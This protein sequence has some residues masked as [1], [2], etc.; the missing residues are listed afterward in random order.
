MQSS[1]LRNK[2]S[3][4]NVKSGGMEPL[5]PHSFELHETINSISSFLIKAANSAI[6]HLQIS[7]ALRTSPETAETLRA[8]NW[9]AA[10]SRT[11]S[12]DA[13]GQDIEVYSWNYTAPPLKFRSQTWL[14][15]HLILNLIDQTLGSRRCLFCLEM[16]I[17][18]TEAFCRN[19]VEVHKGEKS[20]WNLN[21]QNYT[22]LKST[23]SFTRESV[24]LVLFFF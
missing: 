8:Q 12:L 20:N 14:L 5:K 16:G 2:S 19:V 18:Y 17:L 13:F 9:M 1:P 10:L 3:F 24:Y 4:L 22:K 23:W 7:S 11:W 21:Y 15:S 6:T